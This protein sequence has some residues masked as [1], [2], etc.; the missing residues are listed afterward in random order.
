MDR[1]PVGG[2]VL[3]FTG[4]PANDGAVPYVGIGYTG[5]PSRGGWGFSADIGVMALT[6][7]SRVKL[8]RPDGGGQSLDDVLRDLRLS[9]LVQ[10]G[11]SYSF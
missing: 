5:L 2:L 9:P 10:L 11:V 6:P 7:E 8:G 4:D 3:P 1:R